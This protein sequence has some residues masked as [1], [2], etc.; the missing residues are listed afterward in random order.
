MDMTNGRSRW[1][2]G[3]RAQSHTEPGKRYWNLIETS[4]RHGTAV[5]YLFVIEIVEHHMVTG[6]KVLPGYSGM[7]KEWIILLRPGKLLLQL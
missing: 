6:D 5:G 2:N 3:C 4:S 1:T 7:C